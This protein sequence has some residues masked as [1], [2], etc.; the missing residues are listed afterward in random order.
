MPKKDVVYHSLDT[1]VPD[2]DFREGLEF[3]ISQIESY[4]V[5]IRKEAYRGMSDSQS[6]NGQADMINKILCY[7]KAI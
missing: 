2:I 1:C 3:I 4:A 5:E 6:L 7:L